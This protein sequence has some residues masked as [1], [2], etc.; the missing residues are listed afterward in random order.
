MLSQYLDF[1]GDLMELME[2]QFLNHRMV[3]ISYTLKME[4]SQDSLGEKRLNAV[5]NI[6]SRTGI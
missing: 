6:M 4:R 2:S 1:I 3:F 5:E